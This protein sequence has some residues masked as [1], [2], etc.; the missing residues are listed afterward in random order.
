MT[1]FVIVSL[2]SVGGG[3]TANN[4]TPLTIETCRVCMSHARHTHNTPSIPVV[5]QAR[6]NIVGS[7]LCL[8]TLAEYT[9]D[10]SPWSSVY[11]ASVTRHNKL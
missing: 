3:I 5:K 1:Y 11:Y 6:F 9:L 10:V 8:D 7:V 2:H 4:L